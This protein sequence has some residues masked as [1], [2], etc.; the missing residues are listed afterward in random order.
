MS[1][2]IRSHLMPRDMV[3]F[4]ADLGTP[5]ILFTNDVDTVA[6]L[7]CK[8]AVA[9][10][11]RIEHPEIEIW[12]TDRID[13]STPNWYGPFAEVP[14]VLLRYEM[15]QYGM[16]MRLDAISVKPGPVDPAKFLHKEE[17]EQVAPTVMHHEM[18]EVLG[19]FSM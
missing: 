19:T 12:Y 18:S 1:K 3:L 13:L 5:T 2:K 4:N 7:P 10:F 14:G 16:R 11:D 17:Y 9:I 6:G 8:R 15:M